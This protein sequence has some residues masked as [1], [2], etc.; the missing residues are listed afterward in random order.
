MPYKYKKGGTKPE[1]VSTNLLLHFANHAGCGGRGGKV[2]EEEGE[3]NVADEEE[4]E[5]KAKAEGVGGIR[6][7]VGEGLIA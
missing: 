4:E 6:I 1:N 3:D 2:E 7:A 5:V